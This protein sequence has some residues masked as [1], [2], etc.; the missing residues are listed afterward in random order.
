MECVIILNGDKPY[1]PDKDILKGKYVICADGAYTF[2]VNSGIAVDLLVGDLDSLGYTP[3]N[4]NVKKYDSDKDFTDGEL[5]L[6]EAVKLGAK[7]ILFLGGSG[8]RDDHYLAN[9][10]LLNKAMLAGVNAVMMTAYS[11]IMMFKSTVSIKVKKGFYFSIVPFDDNL[12][13]INTEGLK[14]KII[15]KTLR[16]CETLG[17]S[18]ITT[19]N[20]V[21][22]EVKSG[23]GIL[24]ITREAV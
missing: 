2:A 11:D 4:V 22:I 12:H 17:I 24:F 18:N 7:N 8:G 13:I 5:A 21:Q 10:L 14:Y 1:I 3:E 19:D 15:N 20:T 23:A 9:F 6:D 16:R